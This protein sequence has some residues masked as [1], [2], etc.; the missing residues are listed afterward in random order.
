[1]YKNYI[2][3]FDGTL[4]DTY[5]IMMDSIMAS[6]QQDFSTKGDEEKIY[7]LLKSESSKAVAKAYNL[8]FEDFT[9]GFKLFEK[10]DPRRAK[11]FKGT[12]EVLETIQ[13]LGG[14]NFILTHRTLA[15][16]QKMLEQ[17]GLDHLI[18]EIIG[19]D[20]NFPRKPD[21]SALNYFLEKYNLDPKE[22]VMIG[23]RKLD[24]E[25]GD[26]AG[27]A[28]IFFDVEDI[29]NDVVATHRTLSM[30][31]ILKIVQSKAS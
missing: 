19:S 17:D 15:S 13:N 29:L 25:A 24:V 27:V 30:T 7:Y 2:W 6:L 10:F 20:Q 21:P 5:P 31:D 9:E 26:N 3:D 14:Q 8:T 18:V 22:T 23:D 11:P 4:Y 1:M 16:T 28:S 12:Q